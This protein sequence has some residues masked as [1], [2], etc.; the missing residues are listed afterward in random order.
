MGVPPGDVDA[1]EADDKG[2]DSAASKEGA[3]NPSRGKR[4]AKSKTRKKTRKKAQGL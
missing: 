2:Y 1:T 3:P 4:T